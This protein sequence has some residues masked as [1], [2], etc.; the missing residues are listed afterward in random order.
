[1]VK[2]AGSSAPLLSTGFNQ[3]F[4]APLNGCVKQVMKTDP[5]RDTVDCCRAPERPAGKAR[6]TLQYR[7]GVLL[8][9]YVD[10]K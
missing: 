9:I 10:P 2:T 8:Y 5:D 7:W 3:T 1:M 4:S 6:P